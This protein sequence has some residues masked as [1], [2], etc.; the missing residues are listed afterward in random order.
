MDAGVR[1]VVK[2]GLRKAV[3]R[4]SPGGRHFERRITARRDAHAGA[5][6]PA[7]VRLPP[8]VKISTRHP[9]SARRSVIA[10]VPCL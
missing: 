6:Q 10:S 7:D 2:N 5:T 8:H 9:T 1:R 4:Q 3:G